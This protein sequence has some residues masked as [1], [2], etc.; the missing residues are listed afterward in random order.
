MID[1]H[2]TQTFSCSESL[3]LRF[4]KQSIVMRHQFVL[5]ALKSSLEKVFNY[6]GLNNDK[7]QNFQLLKRTRNQEFEL[8]NI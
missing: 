2:I 8:R 3:L 1:A 5:V 7:F 4:A 6:T